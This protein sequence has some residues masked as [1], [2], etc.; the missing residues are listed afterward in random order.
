M[1]KRRT[2]PQERKEFIEE[3]RKRDPRAY[4]RDM[5]FINRKGNIVHP[6]KE[7]YEKTMARQRDYHHGEAVEIDK[8]YNRLINEYG[9]DSKEVHDFERRYKMRKRRGVEESLAVI[10]VA[11]FILALFFLSTNLTGKVIGNLST[12]NS[13]IIGIGLLVI[14]LVAGFFYLKNRK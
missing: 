1:A 3:Q 8:R 7:D 5:S 2:T 10:G 13:T 6:N 4:P 9:E 11:G 12:N 14:G